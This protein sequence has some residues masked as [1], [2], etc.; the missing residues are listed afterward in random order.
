MKKLLWILLA[1]TCAATVFAQ[2]PY[3]VLKDFSGTV[4]IKAAGKDWVPA[5]KGIAM[6]K[7]MSISTGFKSTATLTVGN[8]TLTVSA[9]TRMTLEE[10]VNSKDEKVDLSVQSG[11]IHADVTPPAG[12]RTE[13]TVR[14]PSATASVRGTSFDFGPGFISVTQGSVVFTGKNGSRFLVPAGGHSIVNDR[15]GQARSPA[16]GIAAALSPP[17]PAGVDSEAAPTSSRTPDSVNIEL[18]WVE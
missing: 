7:N 13:F 5:T 12:G 2:T 11:R 9:L 8:S 16:E 10:F 14:S 1:M 6:E 18:T 17:L 4:E 15:T 3:A